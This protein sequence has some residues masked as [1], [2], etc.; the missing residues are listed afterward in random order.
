[1][2]AA[3]QL[4]H[5]VYSQQIGG[6]AADAGTHSIQH[7]A[8]LLDVRLT[9]GVV[10]YRSALG[11]HRCHHHVCR[12]GHGRLRK[13]HLAAVQ[14]ACRKNIFCLV[15]IVEELG[16][17]L[18]KPL[19]MSV[20]MTTAN[21]VAARLGHDGLAAAGQHRPH[22]HNRTA[23]RA[24]A[25]GKVVALEEIHIDVGC[26]ERPAPPVQFANLNAQ[27]AKQPDEIVHVHN[28]GDV[29]HHNL[30]LREQRGA[31]HLKGF[32]LSPLRGD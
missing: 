21:L 14:F 9:G 16:T 23:Q 30:L 3:V 26:L 15:G 12:A 25:A 19:Q 28:V 17:Q 32:I 4:F 10:N 24:V 31:Q 27:I 20:Y 5:A 8:Q 18:L 11:K 1:M 2:A 29:V 13:E 7:P 22:Q 6:D